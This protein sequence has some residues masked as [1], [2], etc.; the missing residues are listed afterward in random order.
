MKFKLDENVPLLVG[1]T[2]AG[3]GHD[4]HTVADESLS[5]ASD[6]A[7]LQACATEERVLV[8][9]DLDFADVRAYPPGTHPGMWIL[10]PSRQSFGALDVLV[11]A[12]LRLAGSG[13]SRRPAVGSG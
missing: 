5:G 6:A 10:R 7:V 2:L 12:G 9:L 3:A 1:A 8:T 11:R 13:T 4:I